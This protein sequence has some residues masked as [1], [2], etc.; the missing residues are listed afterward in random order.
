MSGHITNLFNPKN[1]WKWGASELIAAATL[2]ALAA[3]CLRLC[4][5][6][7]DGPGRLGRCLLLYHLGR[8][9][10]DDGFAAG[11]NL[12]YLGDLFLCFGSICP[13]AQLSGLFAPPPLGCAVHVMM[14][15]TP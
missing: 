10:F 14:G 4:G 2:V 12:F 1:P 5:R 7:D 9:L 13:G 6:F 8:R 15:C 11:G 3:D